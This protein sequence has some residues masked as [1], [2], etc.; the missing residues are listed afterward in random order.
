MYL[1]KCT[2]TISCCILLIPN[3]MLD[4]GEQ[5]THFLVCQNILIQHITVLHVVQIES[6]YSTED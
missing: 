1:Q 6:V 5:V 3:P 4:T 2:A